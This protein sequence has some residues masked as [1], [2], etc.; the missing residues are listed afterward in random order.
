MLR[1]MPKA[2]TEPIS[3][4]CQGQGVQQQA[5]DMFDEVNRDGPWGDFQVPSEE[6][7][8]GRE[9]GSLSPTH[10]LLTPRAQCT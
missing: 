2:G 8:V 6:T 3:K 10:C 1:Q 9:P 4:P 7:L 5:V